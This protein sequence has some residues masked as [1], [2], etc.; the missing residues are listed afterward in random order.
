MIKYD[1]LE[2]I[3]GPVRND[4]YKRLLDW[5]LW[6]KFFQY[7]YYGIPC[8][9]AHFVAY[10]GPEDISAGTAQDYQIKHRR[11]H[12]DFVM[13]ILQQTQAEIDSAAHLAGVSV[14]EQG[15]VISMFDD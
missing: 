3:E 1:Y 2:F 6:L 13:P 9:T 10:S 11:V 14:E 12:R 7:G 8:P 5:A 4:M 15:E